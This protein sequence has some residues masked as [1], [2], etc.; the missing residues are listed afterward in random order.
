MKEL[1]KMIERLVLGKPGTGPT[2]STIKGS[3][4]TVYPDRRVS[5]SEWAQIVNLSNNYK[6]WEKR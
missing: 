4:H 2:V 3:C 5:F 1:N 6:S